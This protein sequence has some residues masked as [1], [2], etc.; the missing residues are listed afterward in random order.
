MRSQNYACAEK[1]FS[2]AISLY[3]DD[4]R[5]KRFRATVDLASALSQQAI[6]LSRLGKRR[7]A[8]KNWA[9][10]ALLTSPA[11][12]EMNQTNLRADRLFAQRRYREAFELYRE[13]VGTELTP[14]EYDNGAA[15]S[16]KR[17]IDLALRGQYLN[18]ARIFKKSA[19]SQAAYYL[20]GQA[21]S[22]IH[23]YKWAYDAYIDELLAYI[24]LPATGSPYGNAFDRPAMLR[25]VALTQ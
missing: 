21:A 8:K 13:F 25:L 3:R 7:A 24:D 4:I 17:G 6:A 19:P 1:D 10:S 11:S 23:D 20:E 22:I 9:E 5:E 18:A 14:G 16:V 15:G 2:H 12:Y